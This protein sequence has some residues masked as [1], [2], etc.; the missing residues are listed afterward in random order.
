MTNSE[1]YFANGGD[2]T[3]LFNYDLNSDSV[4]LDIGGHT[5][6]LGGIMYGKFACNVYIFEPIKSFYQQIKQR[7]KGVDKIKIFNYGVGAETHETQFNL[8]G[9]GTS[10]FLRPDKSPCDVPETAQI[11]SYS[12]VV[13]ELALTAIDV[14]SIN[15]EGGEYIL[16]P[17]IFDEGWT[18]N[19][20]NFQIQF[21]DFIPDCDPKRKEIQTKLSRTHT[22]TFNYDYVWENWTLME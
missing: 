22:Q 13:K 7:F 9:E 12:S 11:R 10:A 1:R 8:W 19:I 15:I 2:S 6:D 17:H 14:C 4:V 21:H 3:H 5:G 20:K 18:R 16:L